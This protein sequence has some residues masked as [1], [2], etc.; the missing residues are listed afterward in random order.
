MA[1]GPGF[2]QRDRGGGQAPQSC[3]DYGEAEERLH[4]TQWEWSTNSSSSSFWTS[5]SQCLGRR[6]HPWEVGSKELHEGVGT[7]LLFPEHC[8]RHALWRNPP[9]TCTGLP[10]EPPRTSQDECQEVADAPEA[11]HVPR[12]GSWGQQPCC[13]MELSWGV[14]W[15]LGQSP[16]SPQGWTKQPPCHEQVHFD[17]VLCKGICAQ[18]D[19]LTD[20][21]FSKWVPWSCLHYKRGT[22]STQQMLLLHVDCMHGKTV[23]EDMWWVCCVLP[24][25]PAPAFNMSNLGWQREVFWLLKAAVAEY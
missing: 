18:S 24:W 16:G 13:L 15:R 19:G 17:Q 6:P 5:A 20:P 25:L 1:R 7:L 8:W 14:F 12:T 11:A 10:K 21:R 22:W 9:W 2:L 23:C 3:E 4:R